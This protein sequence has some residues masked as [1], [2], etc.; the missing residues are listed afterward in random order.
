M[1]LL[2]IKFGI[3]EYS[4]EATIL[5]VETKSIPGGGVRRGGGLLFTRVSQAIVTQIL[6]IMKYNYGWLFVLGFYGLVNG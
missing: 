4:M 5:Q 1:E 3:F 6:H 2:Q